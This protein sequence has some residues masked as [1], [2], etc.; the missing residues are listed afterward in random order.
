MSEQCQNY[1]K[2]YSTVWRAPDRLWTRIT[3]K[4]QNGLLC[5][6]CFDKLAHDLGIEL[7]WECAENGYPT[8]K[9]EY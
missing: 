7:Y 6:S 2:L 5:P 8:E 3:G 9:E 4:K 1:G